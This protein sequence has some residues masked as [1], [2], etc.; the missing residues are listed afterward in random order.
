MSATA[1][2]PADWACTQA[3]PLSFYKL[4]DSRNCAMLDVPGHS[5]RGAKDGGFRVAAMQFFGRLR[6]LE[7]VPGG[8]ISIS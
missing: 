4:D 5:G 6:M 7:I 2:H 1:D 8:A 3:G